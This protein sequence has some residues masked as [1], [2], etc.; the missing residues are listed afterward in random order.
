MAWGLR[1]GRRVLCGY[2][3][4]AGHSSLPVLSNSRWIHGEAMTE[5]SAI[6]RTPDSGAQRSFAERADFGYRINEVRKLAQRV[7]ANG[8][9]PGSP[10]ERDALLRR[11]Q[12]G[13]VYLLGSS[14]VFARDFAE[15]VGRR[16]AVRA[17]V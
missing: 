12:T 8:G 11:L 6:G 3:R 17:V 1:R 15:F 4:E 9:G 14:T 7:V 2:R 16:F 5:I 10:G 13:P